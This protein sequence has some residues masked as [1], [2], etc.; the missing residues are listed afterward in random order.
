MTASSKIRIYALAKELKIDTKRLI[1]EIRSAGVDVSVPSNAIS[2]G[3]A[4]S[5]RIKYLPK[6]G[7]IA[8]EQ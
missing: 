7:A 4:H 3:L 2:K 6:N 5:I 1:E 8:N